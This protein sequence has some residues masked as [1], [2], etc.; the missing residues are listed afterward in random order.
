MNTNKI[1]D[2]AE[3]GKDHD[4]DRGVTVEPEEVLERH[5]IPIEL[6]IK[7]PDVHH[8][9]R[10]QQKQRDT[11]NRRCQNLDDTRRIGGP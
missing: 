9:F 8:T 10:D 11:Q 7:N 6:G 5:R 4:I 2:H 3:C 1:A